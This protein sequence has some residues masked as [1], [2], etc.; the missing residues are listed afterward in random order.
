MPS[1]APTHKRRKAS[2]MSISS[3]TSAHPLRQT[4]FPPE[5]SENHKFS[6]SPSMDMSAVSEAAA[7]TKKKKAGKKSKAMNEDGSSRGGR[8][9]S[10]YSEASGRTKMRGSRGISLEE[11]EEDEDGNTAV[12]TVARTQEEKQKEIEHRAL[13][14]NAFDAKQFSRYE[15]WRSSKLSDAVVRRV[16]LPTSQLQYRSSTDDYRLSTKHFHNR[17]QQA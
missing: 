10:A 6:R 16:S 13:L 12:A 14:V 15:A 11:D 1:S 9:K 4:S 8:A 17:H 2:M 7:P 5:S 3:S